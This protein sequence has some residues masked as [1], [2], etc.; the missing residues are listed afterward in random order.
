MSRNIDRQ[1]Q[2]ARVGKQ[3]RVSLSRLA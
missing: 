3:K 1:N 2:T